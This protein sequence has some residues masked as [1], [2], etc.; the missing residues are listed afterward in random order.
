[1]TLTVTNAAGFTAVTHAVVVPA[2]PVIKPGI[3]GVTEGNTGTVTLNVPVTLSHA[4][5]TNVTVHFATVDTGAAGVATAGVDY[6]PTSGTL[7]FTPGQTSKTVPITVIGDTVKEPPLL[8]GEWILVAFSSAD[9]RHHRPHLLRARD[10]DHRRRRLTGGHRSPRP[11]WRGGPSSLVVQ[12]Q[13][14]ADRRFPPN[15][16]CWDRWS[17]SSMTSR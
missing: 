8:Y 3:G 14:W 12:S 16:A 1:M 2:A 4:A 9:R 5:S 17:S 11:R 13:G 6:V 7:T 15:C 10:R